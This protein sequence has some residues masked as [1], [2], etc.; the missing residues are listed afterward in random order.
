MNR[1]RS[2]SPAVRRWPAIEDEIRALVISTA[3]DVKDKGKGYE[4]DLKRQERRNAKFAFL[5]DERVSHSFVWENR[6]DFELFCSYQSTIYTDHW[7]IRA[8]KAHTRISSL[9][10]MHVFHVSTI[11]LTYKAA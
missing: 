7:Q 10:M 8:I 9:T 11:P 4:Q 5:T 1:A 3:N 6:I 2:R